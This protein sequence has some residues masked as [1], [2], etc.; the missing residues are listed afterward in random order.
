MMLSSLGSVL[1]QNSQQ[2]IDEVLGIVHELKHLA[3]HCMDQN[4]DISEY[5]LIPLFEQVIHSERIITMSSDMISAFMRC[6][7]QLLH[8][9]TRLSIKDLVEI[10]PVLLEQ[11]S[12]QEIITA[13]DRERAAREDAPSETINGAISGCNTCD[14]TQVIKLLAAIK[15]ILVECCEN[16]E[17]NFQGTFTVLAHLT[18]TTTASCA[19]DVGIPISAP[20]TITQPGTYCLIN[21]ITGA[22]IIDADNVVLLMNNKTV[23]GGVP[24][25]ISATGHTDI[26]IQDGNVSNGSS[27]GI[28]IDTCT[29]VRILNVD[30]SNEPAG[31]QVLTTTGIII[32]HCTF[33]NHVDLL[34]GS[35][36]VN[37]SNDNN[38]Q[39][40]NSS[41][42]FNQTNNAVNILNSFNVNCDH[43]EA[44]NNTINNVGAL[45]N[46]INSKN[47]LFTQC[48][49]NNNNG[50]IGNGF[51]IAFGNDVTMIECSVN[52]NNNTSVSGSGFSALELAICSQGV[53]RQCQTNNNSSTIGN[54][55]GLLIFA[56]D[57]IVLES[58]T[59]C[60]NSAL[61]SAIGG[62]V[63]GN[64]HNITAIQCQA[65]DNSSLSLSNGILAD[66]S[67]E[68][69]FRKCM[70]NNNRSTS[71]T[72]GNSIGFENSTCNDVV[73]DHCIS[74]SNQ[75]NSNSSLNFAAG[76]F[77]TTSFK[78]IY[79]TCIAS[80]TALSNPS[81]SGSSFGIR[82]TS[83]TSSCILNCLAERNVVPPVTAK[84][85]NGFGIQVNTCTDCSILNNITTDNSDIGIS[86]LPNAIIT[87]INSV[88]LNNQSQGQGAGGNYTGF[89]AY[90]RIVIFTK[91]TGLFSAGPTAFDNLNIV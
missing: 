26:T 71:P 80:D 15:S 13:G 28:D 58:H 5:S 40:T 89:G 61:S 14:L 27:F 9:A 79:D 51:I 17:I 45:I 19:C 70:A 38:V 74:C 34:A 62:I 1:G 85:G 41:I 18:A 23:S 22:I 16:I 77:S 52:Q 29:N 57:N 69:I 64:C 54:T 68:I 8:G 12:K 33:S 81:A 78:S 20:T 83:E 67:Q 42:T 2:D 46:S 48:H 21:D 49:A 88:Y 43:V 73:Y 84:V 86:N 72:S 30:F 76:F 90:P 36:V 35:F 25:N 3:G 66:S 65:N 31:L 82:L 44:N 6:Y 60:A 24:S 59:A 37:F 56:A 32:D 87:P 39:F 47:L 55:K 7:K 4:I 11:A 10:M 91:S 75:S 53:V 50:D 63:I